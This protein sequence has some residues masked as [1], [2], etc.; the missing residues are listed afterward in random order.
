[1]NFTLAVCALLL[2]AASACCF[3]F[4]RCRSLSARLKEAE[5]QKERIEKYARK[6]EE[7][8]AALHDG[9]AVSNAVRVLQD[10]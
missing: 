6:S 2:L 8:V 9:D 1:M 7:A 4:R 5:R 10:G 3:L